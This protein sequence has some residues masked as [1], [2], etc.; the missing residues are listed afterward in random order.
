MLFVALFS[1]KIA[2]FSYK[3]SAKTLSTMSASC[4]NALRSTKVAKVS[5]KTNTLIREYCIVAKE[6]KKKWLPN[7]CCDNHHIV[8][9]FRCLCR[10]WVGASSGI[11]MMMPVV[12]STSTASGSGS[13]A[14]VTLGAG[15]GAGLGFSVR[16]SK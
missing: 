7:R 16:F 15:A 4:D 9:Y 6:R 11:S 1:L 14:G 8:S 12:S 10:L 5:H 2:T 13:G 3:D